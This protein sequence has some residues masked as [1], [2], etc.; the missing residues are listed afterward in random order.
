M[1]NP[2]NVTTYK[3]QDIVQGVF[4]TLVAAA[5]A[6]GI[7]NRPD[8]TPDVYY[9][10]QMTIP[11]TPTLCVEPAPMTRK[12][13]GASHPPRMQNMF[14]VMIMA[15]IQEINNIESITKEKDLL[16]DSIQDVMHADWT[17]GGLLLYGICSA[18]DPGYALRGNRL[19]RCAK[20][21]YSGMNKSFLITPGLE[22]I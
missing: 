16:M 12:F 5:P 8:G 2:I 4:N 6:L 3:S 22:T 10:D 19:M 13:D 20:I 14:D 17:L 7:S 1:S 21:T 9:G 11:R 18:L 15:Y